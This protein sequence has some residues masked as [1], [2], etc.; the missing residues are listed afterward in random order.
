M[1]E[2]FEEERRNPE[3]DHTHELYLESIR[4][5]HELSQQREQHR[6]EINTFL[7]DLQNKYNT[8]AT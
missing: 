2:R 1:D 8:P 3:P 5:E 7:G 6:Q 4:F